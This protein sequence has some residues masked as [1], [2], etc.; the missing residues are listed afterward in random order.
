M[1]RKQILCCHICRHSCGDRDNMVG[2]RCFRAML[3]NLGWMSN[4][5]AVIF[6]KSKHWTLTNPVKLSCHILFTHVVTTFHCFLEVLTLLTIT[7]VSSSK[8]LYFIQLYLNFHCGEGNLFK[9]KLRQTF[10]KQKFVLRISFH[11]K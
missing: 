9:K 7:K 4:T 11:V 6:K 8:M 2:H 10:I 3:L 5:S 1:R